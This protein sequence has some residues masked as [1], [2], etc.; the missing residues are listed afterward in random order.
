MKKDQFYSKHQRLQIPQA[1]LERKWRTYHNQQEMNELM[2]AARQTQSTQSTSIGAPG[3]GSLSL[4][5]G[6]AFLVNAD[7]ESGDYSYPQS[8]TVDSEGYV[9]TQSRMSWGGTPTVILRKLTSTGEVV[10]EVPLQAEV[11]AVDI[12]PARLRIGLDGRLYSLHKNAIRITDTVDGSEY[13][14]WMYNGGEIP[15]ELASIGFRPGGGFVTIGQYTGETETCVLAV[16]SIDEESGGILLNSETEFLISGN[17][18]MYVNADIVVNDDDTVYIPLAYDLD[19]YGTLLVKWDLIGG[20][21]VLW[22]YNIH[23]DYYDGNDQDCTAMGTDS[24]GNVYLNGYGSSITKIT[25]TGELVWSF[26]MD[27]PNRYGLG[28]TP[29]GDC[30]MYGD[31][32]N[33]LDVIKFSTAG[34]LQWANRI[35]NIGTGDFN[36]AGWSGDGNSQAQFYPGSGL[37][38]MAQWRSSTEVTYQELILKT[39]GEPIIG[40]YDY[41]NFTDSTNTITTITAN[42]V[43]DPLTLLNYSVE[44]LSQAPTNFEP[45]YIIQEETVTIIG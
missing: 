45:A 18:G 11:G 3:G 26:Y 34:T 22:Q 31:P 35:N 20:E 44:Y 7:D 4:G 36:D 33:D 5:S 8:A 39:N 15:L 2:E 38:L 40:V 14:S 12:T 42:P 29:A 41:M 37:Y 30:Y 24:S 32:N 6:W 13:A 10:W 43:N 1:E 21:E 27:G 23:Q 28:V 16:W 19:G 9:Y 17:Q 25:E